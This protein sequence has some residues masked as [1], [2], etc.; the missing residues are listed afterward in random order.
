MKKLVSDLELSIQQISEAYLQFEKNNFKTWEFVRSFNQKQDKYINYYWQ[1]N[2][3]NDCHYNDVE[4]KAYYHDENNPLSKSN[5]DALV[6]FLKSYH[7]MNNPVIFNKI[8]QIKQIEMN[9]INNLIV[10][11]DGRLATSSNDKTIK[12]YNGV[13]LRLKTFLV[14][15][16]K[17]TKIDNKYKKHPISVAFKAL[18]SLYKAEILS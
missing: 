2:V 18:P 15:C 9:Q 17:Q 8:V 5:I 16:I 4:F 1:E 11:K 14:L 12:I 3:I 6:A 7:V 13:S 10:L